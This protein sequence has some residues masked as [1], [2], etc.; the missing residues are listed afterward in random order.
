MAVFPQFPGRHRCILAISCSHKSWSSH[1]GI[2]FAF[3]WRNTEAIL[4]SAPSATWTITTQERPV[5][6]VPQNA[7]CMNAR[8]NPVRLWAVFELR[9]YGMNVLNSL[10]GQRPKATEVS[11]WYGVCSVNQQLT[12]SMVRGPHHPE[13]DRGIGTERRSNCR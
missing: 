9:S 3:W 13:E 8:M 7:P 11:L 4:T 12:S 1:R 5:C 2:P 10:Q 6:P